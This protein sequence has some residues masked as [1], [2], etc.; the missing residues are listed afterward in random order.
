MPFRGEL[1]RILTILKLRFSDHDPAL[2]EFRIRTADGLRVLGRF[3]SATGVLEGI[4][5]DQEQAAPRAEE[6]SRRAGGR[7]AE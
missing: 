7:K 4:T 5:Q 3:E 1:H 6:R 2:R